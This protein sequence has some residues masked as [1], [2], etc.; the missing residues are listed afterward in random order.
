[1]KEKVIHFADEILSKNLKNIFMQKNFLDLF[2]DLIGFMP[3]KQI[4][5]L[6]FATI[7]SRLLEFTSIGLALTVLFDSNKFLNINLTKNSSIYIIL[8]FVIFL[9][10]RT[11][12]NGNLTI[13]KQQLRYYLT[14]KLRSEFLLRIANTSQKNLENIGRSEL[15]NIMMGEISRSVIA[16]DQGILSIQNFITFFVYFIGFF[17]FSAEYKTTFFIG[18]ICTIISFI[19][20]KS[21]SWELGQLTSSMNNSLQRTLGDFINGLKNVKAYSAEDWFHNR[22]TNESK[23]IRN[24]S[25]EKLKRD[26]NFN[27]LRDFLISLIIGIWFVYFSKSMEAITLSTLLI[28]AYKSST[29]ASLIFKSYRLA[30]NGLPAFLNF[31]KIILKLPSKKNYKNEKL[32]DSNCQKI[33]SIKWINTKFQFNI[34]SQLTLEKNSLT[35]ITGPSGV[36]KTSLLDSF[37]GLIHEKSSKWEIQI[38]KKSSKLKG[39]NGSL[40]LKELIG[41]T[42]QDTFLFE[43]SILENLF[44]K[45]GSLITTKEKNFIYELF[46]NLSLESILKRSKGYDYIFN[47]SKEE[48]SGGETKRFG[49]ARTILQ[50][51]PIE[52]YDEPTA[53]LDENN[54]I[55]ISRLLKK[56]S[57]EKLILVATHD[58][59]LISYADKIVELKK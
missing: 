4:R 32:N 18:F 17:Y 19:T 26:N 8:S 51:K 53:S 21:N 11:Y 50:N 34:E 3:R 10:L 37:C 40:I 57:K 12:I 46:K 25:K 22:F 42:T 28:M 2:I 41:Y 29:S 15:R 36:G 58:K 30:I 59:N 6:I 55:L 31:K 56:R 35:I 47:L 52:V 27:S 16:M 45:N 9:S 49:I 39:D 7:L 13:S 20:L 14:D 38:N 43:G 1:M 33:N 24:L 48:L 44:L 5:K 54:S 23:K